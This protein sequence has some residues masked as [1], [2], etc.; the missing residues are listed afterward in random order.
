MHVIIAGGS[1]LI[2]RALTDVLV[3][4]GW[5][6][7]IL[8]RRPDE[9]AG[10]PAQVEIV[11]W[12]GAT[13]DGWGDRIAGAD[14]VVNLAGAGLGDKRWTDARK[15]QILLSRLQPGQA[16]VNAIKAA[17]ERPKLLI[18]ASAV[19]YYGPQGDETVDE[20]SKPG[21]DYLANVCQRWEESTL[22]AESLGVRRAIARTGLVLSP[23]G[24]ALSQMVLPFRLGVGGRLG[25][26]KQWL[27]WI[28]IDD[29]V[30]ALR[31]LLV[32]SDAHGPYNLT[33]PHP[34]RNSEFARTV[35]RVLNRPAA[36][37]TPEFALR[38]AFGEMAAVVLEGQRAVPSRLVA[39]GF[40]F[41][42]TD[43]EAALTDILD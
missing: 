23:D 37:P 19:G 35:G 13:T 5:D 38:L 20:D 22:V 14:A 29:E 24:G 12:D 11:G 4:D 7:I 33:A 41:E 34:V 16:I 10:L 28:H 36:I 32:S 2:G 8:S 31:H 3:S 26:G 21:S 39:S 1:G 40:E 25:S 9:V 42:Y 30:A 18:Q 15:R 27:P 43:L 17:T 6:V